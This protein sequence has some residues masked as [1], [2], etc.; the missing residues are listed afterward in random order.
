MLLLTLCFSEAYANLQRGIRDP[1]V[2]YESQT[3]IFVCELTLP[4]DETKWLKDGEEIFESPKYQ[5]KT[6]DDIF[7]HL[8]VYDVNKEDE[9][10]YT[11]KVVT[12]V[13]DH[14]VLVQGWF[15]R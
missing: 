10:I 12:R 15:L 13:R 11:F 5:M 14:E 9:G 6:V 2:K 4:C 1:D 3:V 7:Y 8:E